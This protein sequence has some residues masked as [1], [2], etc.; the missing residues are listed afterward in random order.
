MLLW[1][2]IA[3]FGF[4]AATIWYNSSKKN[5]QR[6]DKLKSIRKQIEEN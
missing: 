4:S 1:I 5:N 6:N 3:V 2:A